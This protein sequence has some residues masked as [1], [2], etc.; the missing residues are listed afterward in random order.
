[1]SSSYT[2]S[3]IPYLQLPN[4]FSR[5]DLQNSTFSYD[6]IKYCKLDFDVEKSLRSFNQL[7]VLSPTF[8]QCYFQVLPTVNDRK[9]KME[10]HLP[11]RRT[12][13][14]F[15]IDVDFYKTKS[16][17][18]LNPLEPSLHFLAPK[19]QYPY[20]SDRQIT[21]QKRNTQAAI[22]R[23]PSKKNKC[24]DVRNRKSVRFSDAQIN[25]MT[26]FFDTNKVPSVK[27]YEDVAN[28]VG[29]DENQVKR[30]FSKMRRI[31]KYSKQINE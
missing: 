8:T 14:E 27:S 10:Q 7:P 9:I 11:R 5:F 25:K 22:K 4:N 16:S 20:S 31:A 12:T 1:M 23:I 28:A 18:L 21:L 2:I 13:R 26:M 29:L 6:P 19:D 17:E 3:T 15:E 30:W 24:Q